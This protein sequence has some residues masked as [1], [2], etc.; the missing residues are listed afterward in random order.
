MLFR[1]ESIK[2]YLNIYGKDCL[3]LFILADCEFWNDGKPCVFCSLKPT[4]IFHDEVVKFK[5]IDKIDEALELAFSSGDIIN[6]MIITGGSR[7]DRQEEIDRYRDRRPG[8]GYG[9]GKA[10]PRPAERGD[11]AAGRGGGR[12]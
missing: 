3:N 8:A 10:L 12:F 4:Q 11:R 7:R 6:W 2:K 9:A 5:A 1:S